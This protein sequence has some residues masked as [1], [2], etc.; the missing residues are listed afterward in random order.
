MYVLIRVWE[1]TLWVLLWEFREVSWYLRC[2]SFQQTLASHKLQ[3]KEH[4][5][6]KFYTPNGARV[7]LYEE[8]AHLSCPAVSQSW[9]WTLKVFPVAVP[10]EAV[11]TWGATRVEP[12]KSHISTVSPHEQYLDSFWPERHRSMI[13]II[14]LFST[15]GIFF[16]YPE[17][18]KVLARF[19]RNHHFE[20]E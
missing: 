9:R 17:L 1:E 16:I 2:S 11:Y 15:S 7:E 19:H 20:M 13:S 10:L 5:A 12:H 14:S 6:E 18:W 4:L 8:Q 3:E